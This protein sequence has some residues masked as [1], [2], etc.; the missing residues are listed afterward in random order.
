MGEFKGFMNYEKQQLHELSLVD[1]LNNHEAFQQR[2]TNEE[3][4]EQGARCM[5]CGT[6]FCQTGEPFGRETIGCPIGNYIPEWND[7]V[8]R[9]DF[10]TAYE[11]FERNK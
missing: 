3:A 8:Y 2:F 10:K 1:R 5:D 4:A 7:L 11:R 9:H 6:P